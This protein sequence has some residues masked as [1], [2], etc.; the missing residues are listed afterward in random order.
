M[1]REAA[2]KE[3]G[4]RARRT[5]KPLS[6]TQAEFYGIGNRIGIGFVSVDT[7]SE[8]RR[9]EGRAEAGPARPLPLRNMRQ[10]QATA[11]HRQYDRLQIEADA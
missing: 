2:V 3:N 7:A 9:R 6:A 8:V 10:Y 1:G 5:L 4:F 11:Q